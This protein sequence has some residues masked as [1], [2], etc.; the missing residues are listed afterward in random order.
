MITLSGLHCTANTVTH[1]LGQKCISGALTCFYPHTT[2]TKA[3]DKEPAGS[4]L[5][6]AQ[7][8]DA[9]KTLLVGDTPA[10]SSKQQTKPKALT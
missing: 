9:V 10:T 5:Q 1:F 6:A 7:P 8:E 3:A 2:D 4:D